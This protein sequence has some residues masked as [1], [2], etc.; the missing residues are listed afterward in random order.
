VKAGR[1]DELAVGFLYTHPTEGSKL[2]SKIALQFNLKD[3]LGSL[4]PGEIA[5]V[6]PSQS[7][8]VPA[9]YCISPGLLFCGLVFPQDIKSILRNIVSGAKAERERTNSDLISGGDT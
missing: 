1:E 5:R 3:S 8:C 9:C 7:H 4:A 2:S 6:S